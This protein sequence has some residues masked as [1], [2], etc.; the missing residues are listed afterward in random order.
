MRRDAMAFNKE[1]YDPKDDSSKGHAKDGVLVIAT[2]TRKDGDEEQ[3]SSLD[4]CLQFPKSGRFVPGGDARLKGRLIR[5]HLAGVKVVRVKDGKAAK[6]VTALSI[7]KELGW[8]DKIKAAEKREK[9]A[10]KAKAAA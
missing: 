2:K 5:A 4:G 9:E 7:A 1:K 6:P 8:G 3:E 10:A